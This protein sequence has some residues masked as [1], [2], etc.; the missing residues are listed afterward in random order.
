METS[1]HTINNNWQDQIQELASQYGIPREKMEVIVYDIQNQ[2][3]TLEW[4]TQPHVQKI[5]KHRK[6]RWTQVSETAMLFFSCH[7]GLNPV[8]NTYNNR[9]KNNSPTS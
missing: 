6:G 7:A 1:Y 4:L 2:E 8:F 9:R 3:Q 5:V